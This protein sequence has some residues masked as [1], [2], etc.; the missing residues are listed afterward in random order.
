[1]EVMMQD[2]PYNTAAHQD[3]FIK[4]DNSISFTNNEPFTSS[5]ISIQS[6]SKEPP[7]VEDTN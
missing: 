4:Q 7:V 1:M 2:N 5:T 3:V 6:N